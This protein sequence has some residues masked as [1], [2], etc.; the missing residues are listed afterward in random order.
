MTDQTEQS[1]ITSYP[2]IGEKNLLSILKDIKEKKEKYTFVGQEEEISDKMNAETCNEIITNLSFE[3][4]CPKQ[5]VL[6]AVTKMIQSGGTNASK[7]AMIVTVNLKELSLGN[8]R[9]VI[10]KYDKFGTVR[11]FAKGIRDIVIAIA[12]TNQLPGPLFKDLR[13]NNPEMEFEENWPCWCN[14]IHS[15]NYDPECPAQIREALQRREQLLRTNIRS[16]NTSIPQRK[17]KGRKR[18]NKRGNRK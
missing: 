15:D 10:T 14:E 4:K 1:T 16:Q 11:K 9:Q 6:Y 8:L 2:N 3:M 5:E 12:I 7:K 18:G 17:S 13:R